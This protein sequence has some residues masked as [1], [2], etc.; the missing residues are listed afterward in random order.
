MPKIVRVTFADLTVTNY[1]YTNVLI[2]CYYM[3]D[4]WYDKLDF[5]IQL[6][7]CVHLF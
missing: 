3:D 1:M 2:A 5:G 6:T 7:V 4:F